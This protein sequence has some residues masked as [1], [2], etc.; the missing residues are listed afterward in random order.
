[1]AFSLSVLILMISFYECFTSFFNF[2]FFIINCMSQRIFYCQH[3]E[4]AHANFSQRSL[5]F[6]FLMS[7]TNYKQSIVSVETH[8]H[9]RPHTHTHTLHFLLAAQAVCLHMCAKQ[10]VRVQHL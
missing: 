10:N 9:T 8:I 1:M 5:S 6:L 2:F 4:R 7:R 3:V